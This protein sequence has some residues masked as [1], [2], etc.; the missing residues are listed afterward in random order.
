MESNLDNTK[1]MVV[2]LPI[3]NREN[4]SLTHKVPI[5][6]T[7]SEGCSDNSQTYLSE[8]NIKMIKDMFCDKE[9]YDYYMNILRTMRQLAENACDTGVSG[10]NY[11]TS[12]PYFHV[13]KTMNELIGCL[14]V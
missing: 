2:Y 13:A 7:P 14:W 11:D 5:N 12:S 6:F 9:N 10:I 4:P 3:D 1:R 8:K